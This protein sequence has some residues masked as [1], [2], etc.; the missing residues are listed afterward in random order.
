MIAHGDSNLPEAR[1][2]YRLYMKLATIMRSK[3]WR[4][5]ITHEAAGEY[6]HPFHKI[7]HKVVNNLVVENNGRRGAAKQIKQFS[8]RAITTTQ[9]PN[10]PTACLVPRHEPHALLHNVEPTC[11]DGVSIACFSSFRYFVLTLL[12]P[13]SRRTESFESTCSSAY[14]SGHRPF[15]HRSKKQESK[16]SRCPLSCLT[17]AT[18]YACDSMLRLLSRASQIGAATRIQW[19]A[20][21]SSGRAS[22]CPNEILAGA[23]VPPAR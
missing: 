16:I 4:R 20:R 6:G 5:V 18:I 23:P 17:F 1:A 9:Q 2:D 12:S 8:V 21:E 15:G 11:H 14:T 13:S 22:R 10:D 3:P 7:M 19:D